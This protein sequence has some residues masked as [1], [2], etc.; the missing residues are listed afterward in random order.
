MQLFSMA[1]FFLLGAA[2]TA[3]LILN[4]F[5]LP[6]LP[7]GEPA[8]ESGQQVAAKTVSPEALAYYQC[9]MHPEVIEMDAQGRETISSLFATYRATPAMMPARFAGRID[10]QG[11]DRVICD[12]IAGMTDGYCAATHARF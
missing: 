11:L 2:M 3:F 10:D 7:D 6:F 12:Y 1:V 8:G 5:G 9:P 4:P